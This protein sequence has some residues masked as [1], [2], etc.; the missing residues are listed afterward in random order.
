MGT[1]TTSRRGSLG[2]WFLSND[3][4]AD[5]Y[6]QNGIADREWE[7]VCHVDGTGSEGTHRFVVFGGVGECGIVVHWALSLVL[8]LQYIIEE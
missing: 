5:R 8:Y 3:V 1:G 7:G 2:R 6:L 4:D